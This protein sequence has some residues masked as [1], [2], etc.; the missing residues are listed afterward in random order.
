M[1][2]AI[3]H[4]VNVRYDPKFL[5]YIQPDPVKLYTDT[6]YSERVSNPLML[7]TPVLL[8]SYSRQSK[9]KWM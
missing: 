7:V 5:L 8:R 2:R 1:V 3:E 6:T 4:Q 9:H